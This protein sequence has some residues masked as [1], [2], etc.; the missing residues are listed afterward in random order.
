MRPNDTDNDRIKY[1]ERLDGKD[2]VGW[3]LSEDLF[4]KCSAYV[5]GYTREIALFYPCILD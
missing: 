4:L 5:K 3:E 1:Y 2:S